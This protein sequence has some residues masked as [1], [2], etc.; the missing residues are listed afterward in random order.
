[1]CIIGKRRLPELGVVGEDIQGY[2]CAGM[3]PMAC[4]LVTMELHRGDG[5]L[6]VVLGVHACVAM[7][8]IEM[9]GS[10]EQKARWLPDLARM[11]KLGALR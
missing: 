1:M 11:D 10:D 5:S 4:G 9:C 2:G 6:G 8:S 7:K 3:S